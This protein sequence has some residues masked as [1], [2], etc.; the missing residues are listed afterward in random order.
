MTEFGL[1]MVA[2]HKV[3]RVIYLCNSWIDER[4][5]SQIHWLYF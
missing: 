3:Q 1:H 5:H 4:I 2:M